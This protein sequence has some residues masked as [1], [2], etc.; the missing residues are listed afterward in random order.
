MKRRT[1]W[2]AG[3]SAVLLTLL[4]AATAFGYQTTTKGSIS[5]RCVGHLTL[6][7]TLLD[8]N[9]APVSGQSVAWSF[10]NAPSTADTINETP[11]TTNSNGV[12]STTVTLG[13]ASGNRQIRATAGDVSAE[14]VLRLPCSGELPST[15]T[16]PAETAR[17]GASPVLAMLLALAFA[18]GGGLT[19]RR[20]ATARR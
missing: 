14:A 10:V 17:G 3:L 1:R 4:M 13:P 8:A 7:A 2:I 15:S 6:S 9:G 19:L 5:I 16:L 11:T 18:T 12:T 20:L